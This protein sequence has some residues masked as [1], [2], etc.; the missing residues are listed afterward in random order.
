MKPISGSLKP[1]CKRL[2][3]SSEKVSIAMEHI[4]R[5][6]GSAITPTAGLPADH[7][8]TAYLQQ[9]IKVNEQMIKVEKAKGGPDFSVG[10]FNQSI[11][12]FQNT[13]GTEKFYDFGKRFHGVQASVSFPLFSKPF[14]S[15]VRAAK[16]DQ[17]IAESNL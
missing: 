8:L 9:E 4:T 14:A 2:L 5:L 10:Y 1:V 7:P 17:Q 3:H 16:V 6:D 13:D 12:G 11:Y 15:R